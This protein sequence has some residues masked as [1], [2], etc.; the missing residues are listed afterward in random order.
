MNPLSPMTSPAAFRIASH[1][2]AFQLG[3]V[4]LVAGNRI[5]YESDAAGEIRDDQ[6]PV[7]RGLVFPRPQLALA[8]PGPAWPQGAIYQG[9]RSPGGLRR[10]LRGWPELRGRLTDQWRQE[11]D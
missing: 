6:G 1:A 4:M 8:R 7:A 2:R 11:R 5:G 3:H 10:L 9:D